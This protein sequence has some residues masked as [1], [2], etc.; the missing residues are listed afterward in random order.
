MK[1]NYLR[2]LSISLAVA[3]SV[4]FV[5][6]KGDDDDGNDPDDEKVVSGVAEK[7]IGVWRAN[8]YG[9]V[10]I[11]LPNGL[12][13]EYHDFFSSG[14][15]RFLSEWTYDESTKQLATTLDGNGWTVSMITNEAWTGISLKRGKSVT[16]ERAN[17]YFFTAFLYKMD[18]SWTGEM[19]LD[20]Q[21]NYSATYIV[22]G[23]MGAYSPLVSATNDNIKITKD[24]IIASNVTLQA[25]VSK[26]NTVSVY[27]DGKIIDV[28]T[29]NITISNYG[30]KNAKLTIDGTVIAT[31]GKINK[32]Y[33]AR[34]Y[35]KDKAI[36][37]VEE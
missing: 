16:Y 2:L 6:C 12:C 4:G 1:K 7:F 13:E 3:M 22:N 29:G 24:N 10:F 36:V 21:P 25:Y 26:S 32:T 19:S 23:Y 27:G 14:P 15:G 20:L 34:K 37:P 8:G 28:F 5:S 17:N 35:I 9:D 31:G 30:K 11:F 33:G 18:D